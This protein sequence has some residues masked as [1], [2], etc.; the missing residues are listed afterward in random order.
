MKWIIATRKRCGGMH[1]VPSFK[2][3]EPDLEGCDRLDTPEFRIEGNAH[4]ISK[5]DY[6]RRLL[7]R[8]EMRFVER[9]GFKLYDDGILRDVSY[10]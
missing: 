7:I 10:P 3:Y 8:E 6:L 9:Y 5:L 2:D 4:E 1:G